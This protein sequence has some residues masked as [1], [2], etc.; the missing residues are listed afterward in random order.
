MG[1]I[2]EP[3]EIDFTVVSKI[4]TADEEKEF[5]ELIRKQ[6]EKLGR[7]QIPLLQD[8]RIN[9]GKYQGD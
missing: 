3:I 6:K 8:Q 2:K 4:W 9:Y 7:Q 1:L 5:S